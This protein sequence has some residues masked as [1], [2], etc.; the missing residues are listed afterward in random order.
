MAS[1][2]VRAADDLS[3]GVKSIVDRVLEADVT[4]TIAQRGKEIAAVLSDA[5]ETA[6]ERAQQAWR[7]SAPVRRDAQRN[8][9]RAS[10]DASK[11]SRRTWSKEV[12]PQ[13]KDLW[14]R[15]TVAIGA[16]GAA[17]PA[18]RELVDAAAARLNLR[19]REQRHWGAFFLG[20]IL[21]AIGGAA[22]ALL[23][24]PKPG[25]EMRDELAEKARGAA[26]NAP[27][28]VPLFQREP[29]D[30]NS[31]LGDVTDTTPVADAELPEVP[32]VPREVDETL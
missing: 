27:E 21:G 4:E 19:R 32:P 9:G 24:A 13:L 5:T 2:T 12:R 3:A 16:A 25:R 15:R 29:A 8:L 28:W 30:G 18:G 7:E 14:K 20:L 17:V 6:A 23:T 31:V 26:E 1:G 22:I 10:R 11:W